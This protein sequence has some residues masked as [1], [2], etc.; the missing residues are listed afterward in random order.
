MPRPNPWKTLASR[1][2][3]ENAW[4]RVREDEVIRP[5]G[6]HGI[7]G[8]VEVRPSVGVVAINDRGEM[9]LTGQWRYALGRYSLEIPRGGSAPGETDLL[10]V[11]RRELR[12]ECGYDAASWRSL[13]TVDVQSGVGTDVEHLFAASQLT[14]VG[15]AQEGDEEVET[16]WVPFARVVEMALNG[17]IREAC[18]VAAILRYALLTSSAAALEQGD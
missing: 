13:G 18:S 6:A 9:A 3:Y 7:Y 14:F 8:V 5:D 2:A 11:A 1:I 4:I 17:E 16:E 12:E 10:A 15:V